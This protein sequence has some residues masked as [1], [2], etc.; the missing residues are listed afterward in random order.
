MVNPQRNFTNKWPCNVPTEKTRECSNKQVTH[1]LFKI[2]NLIL[3]QANV[4]LC[5]SCASRKSKYS[6]CSLILFIIKTFFLHISIHCNLHIIL[7]MKKIPISCKGY[8]EQILATKYEKLCKELIRKLS[9]WIL[10]HNGKMGSWIKLI[11]KT[12]KRTF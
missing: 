9:W 5:V 12:I 11:F 3:L 7:S 10:K 6:L 8:L 4:R 2:N 1:N